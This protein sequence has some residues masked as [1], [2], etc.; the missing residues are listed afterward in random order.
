ME[1]SSG[2]VDWDEKLRARSSGRNEG[3]ELEEALW[4]E[5]VELNVPSSPPR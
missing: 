5:G 1:D 4:F 3:R 2:S